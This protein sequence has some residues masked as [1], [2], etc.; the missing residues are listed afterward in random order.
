[1]PKVTEA[2]LEAR[3]QQILE[4]ASSCFARKGFHHSTMHD[5]CA[6]AQLSPGAVYRYFSSKEEIIEAMAEEERVRALGYI[7][8]AKQ[9]GDTL[10]LLNE[11]ANVFFGV[12]EDEWQQMCKL[13]IEVWAEGL[14][15]PRVMGLVRRTFDSHL[16]SFAEIVR[17]AQERG[18]INPALDPEAVAHVMM[19]FFE[20]LVL[21]KGM[22]PGIDVP[23]YV[24]VMKAMMKGTFWTGRTLEGS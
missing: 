9:R 21:Q 24:A 6:E 2:H 5:I 12:V 7:E 23:N 17:M 13:D 1:M 16:E 3:R 10:E 15:N 19:S 4:A 20:G 18:D 14:R 11:L 8:A 22:D